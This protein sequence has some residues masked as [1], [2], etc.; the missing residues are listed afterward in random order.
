MKF[1]VSAAIKR[2]MLLLTPYFVIQNVSEQVKLILIEFFVFLLLT[3]SLEAINLPT[4]WTSVE[5]VLELFMYKKIFNKQ[6]WESVKD[7]QFYSGLELVLI[8]A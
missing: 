1:D 2:F 3:H 6:Q 4:A 7:I 8:I 5:F